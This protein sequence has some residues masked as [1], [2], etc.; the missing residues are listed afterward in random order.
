MTSIEVYKSTMPK[1]LKAFFEK[2]QG[3]IYTAEYFLINPIMKKFLDYSCL[4]FD[5]REYNSIPIKMMYTSVHSWFDKK[6]IKLKIKKYKAEFGDRFIL[7]L[8]TI[9]IGIKG[10]EPIL[11]PEHLE[12]DLRICKEMNVKEVVIFRL[13]GLNK[14]YVK[15]INKFL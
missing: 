3:E 8:G 7:G 5:P 6:F 13:G 2:Y 4:T 9:A 11:S 12:R 10:N 1:G 14:E 15:V